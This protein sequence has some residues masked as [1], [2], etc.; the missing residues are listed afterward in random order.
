MI[1]KTIEVNKRM[2]FREIFKK[3][4][5][6]T[7][8]MLIRNVNIGDNLINYDLQSEENEVSITLILKDDEVFPLVFRIVVSMENGDLNVINNLKRVWVDEI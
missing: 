8:D 3:I 4:N 6:N 7:E 5:K 1:T 2:T